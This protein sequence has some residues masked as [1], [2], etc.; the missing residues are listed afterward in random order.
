MAHL[1]WVPFFMDAITLKTPGSQ[2]WCAM[3]FYH[4]GFFSD[5]VVYLGRLLGF[6]VMQLSLILNDFRKTSDIKESTKGKTEVNQQ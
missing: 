2:G 1:E 5:C 6:K 4:L 3:I